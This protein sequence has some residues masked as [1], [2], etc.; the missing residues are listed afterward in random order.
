M[1][2]LLKLNEINIKHGGGMEV[3]NMFTVEDSKLQNLGM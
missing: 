3:G 1:V 2:V